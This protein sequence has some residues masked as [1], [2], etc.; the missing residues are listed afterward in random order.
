MSMGT[1]I[2]ALLEA[3]AL[4]TYGTDLFLNMIPETPQICGAVFETAGAAPTAGFG[5]PGIQHESPGVQIRF[6]GEPFDEAGPRVKAQTAYRL[7]MTVQGQTLSG[8]KYLTL[9]PNQAPFI[10]DR[11][12]DQRIVWAFNALALKELSSEL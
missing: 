7:F 9:H 5:F 1:E 3:N 4:G 2:I 11:D 8:T 6:R 12:G 10:L